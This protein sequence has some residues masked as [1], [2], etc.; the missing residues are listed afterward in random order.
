[1]VRPDIALGEHSQTPAPAHELMRSAPRPL[2]E[3]IDKIDR[4]VV[5]LVE[6]PS[7]NE[8]MHAL[9]SGL[10][11][12]S[13]LTEAT[14]KVVK[15]IGRVVSAS[16]QLAARASRLRQLDRNGLRPVRLNAARKAVVALD[17]TLADAK[18]SQIALSLD[19]GW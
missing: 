6:G 2:N 9:R 19:R 15:A 1:M 12:I 8:A 4:A 16:D 11:D 7:P 3:L 18:P 17:E 14:P 13:A 10:S 5:E